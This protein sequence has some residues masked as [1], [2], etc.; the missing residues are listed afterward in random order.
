MMGKPTS[1]FVKVNERKLQS[2]A[3]LTLLI[4]ILLGILMGLLMDSDF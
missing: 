1:A 2:N 4:Y 3:M